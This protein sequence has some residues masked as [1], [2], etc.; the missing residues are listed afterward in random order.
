MLSKRTDITF[1]AHSPTGEIV[2]TKR[3]V[4]GVEGAKTGY[5]EVVYN[6]IDD[7]SGAPLANGI[8]PLRITSNGE[9]IGKAYIVVFNKK[10][11]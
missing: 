10:R 3:I 9:V 7:I 4:A 6:G 11:P 5:N 8:Y 2:W 1:Y